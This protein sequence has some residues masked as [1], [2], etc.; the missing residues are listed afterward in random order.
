M[1][2]KNIYQQYL[3]VDCRRSF[4]R[5]ELQRDTEG[6]LVC[7]NC[8]LRRIF[9]KRRRPRVLDI[10]APFGVSLV[11][12]L[13]VVLILGMLASIT[14]PTIMYVRE[15]ALENEWRQ[16]FYDNQDT[17]MGRLAEQA[18][19]ASKLGQSLEDIPEL[20]E[21]KPEELESLVDKLGECVDINSDDL[22]MGAAIKALMEWQELQGL[23]WP[24]DEL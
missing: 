4:Y 3:C 13:A 24:E 5:D 9:L 2:G 22:R 12:I 14:I 20:S 6:Q 17:D 19:S 18:L 10:P 11:E 1:S 16:L 8:R 21:V 7:R 23:E 15:R